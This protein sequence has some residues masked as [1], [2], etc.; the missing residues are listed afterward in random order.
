MALIFGVGTGLFVLA[1]LWALAILLCAVFS[2]ADKLRGAAFG[3]VLLV[4]IITLILVFIPRE[5]SNAQPS[6]IKITD[7]TFIPRVLM[8]T[9]FGLFAFLSLIFMFSLHWTEPIHAKPIKS[10]RF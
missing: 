9:L 6:D 4:I 10:K 8:L 2:R 1:I 3:I 7:Q 5:D